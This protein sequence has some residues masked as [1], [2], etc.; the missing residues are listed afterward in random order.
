MKRVTKIVLAIVGLSLQPD[1][2][3]Q[4][5]DT[6]THP[7]YFKISAQYRVRPEFRQGY[8]TLSTDTSSGAFFVGQRAR[9][10][11]DYKKGGL[12]FYTSI[13][14]SRTWGDEE[15]RKDIGGLQVN[16]L[17]VDM[18]LYDKLTIKLGRQEF[19]YDDHR[20][21]GNLDWA[22]LTISHDALLLKYTNP[23][24]GI[25]W[26]AA[27]AFNQVGEPFFGTNYNL[28]N[29]K[30][31]GFTWA[32]VDLSKIHS[33]V[34][35][36]AALNGL[37]ST[38]TLH[39]S[40]K[41]T[42][43][44]GAIFNYQ[45]KGWKSNLG[46]YYQ[47]GKSENNL[48]VSAYMVNAYAQYKYKKMIVGLGGDLLSGNTKNTPANETNCFTTL[49]ATNHKFY[50]YMDY[51][52][53]IPGDTKQG[54][55]MDLYLR[56]GVAPAKNMQFTLDAHS[57]SLA[58]SNNLVTG[59]SSKDLGTEFDLL[60]DYQISSV[61]QLQA[62]YCMLMATDN[63]EKLKG[64]DAQSYNGWSYVMLKVSPTLFLH[65]FTK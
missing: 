47:G 43:T 39:T 54:G 11:L 62:G 65:E 48:T 17:W 41:S 19:A 26:H 60:F 59:N 15:Q 10:I 2:F 7:D 38:D 3:A 45:H 4:N 20:I 27:G 13:Q 36:I 53:A 58:S 28:K 31:L 57:F 30:F 42:Y 22:N 5:L 51:F 1:L 61:V 49:Y 16:E 64:G 50:G 6:A 23:Q 35:G 18:P 44:A 63:M 12:S 9:I 55:L 37:K 29:Y 56:V 52:L 8:R 40:D 14:D 24:K 34:S 46:A 25:Q 33:S 32:K 21:L